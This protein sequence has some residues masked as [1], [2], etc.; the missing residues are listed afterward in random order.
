MKPKHELEN[1]WEQGRLSLPRYLQ[2]LL[3]RLSAGK[4]GS[5]RL[6]DCCCASFPSCWLS[7]LT[8]RMKPK[9]R[10]GVSFVLTPVCW[11][12]VAF[13]FLLT[14]VSLFSD[15]T[16]SIFLWHLIP[17][18]LFSSTSHLLL[19]CSVCLNQ[20]LCYDESNLSVSRLS[21]PQFHFP[22]TQ[23]SNHM[24]YLKFL[25]AWLYKFCFA[26]AFSWSVHYSFRLDVQCEVVDSEINH[27]LPAFSVMRRD[28]GLQRDP[29]LFSCAGHSPKYRRLCPC[30]D[31]R[32][33]Q[34]ALCRDCL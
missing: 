6:K 10:T 27:I 16:P 25:W 17:A 3:Y 24:F 19:Q 12:T 2:S 29:L 28:C 9:Q 15:L 7:G 26:E 13:L 30:R 20:H 8:L 1:P 32:R 11:F 5:L 14:A 23:I 21:I 18:S 34:V 33:G 4:A 31:F 22:P